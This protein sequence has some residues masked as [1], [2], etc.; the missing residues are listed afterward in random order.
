MFLDLAKALTHELLWLSSHHLI[1]AIA[2]QRPSAV[3][4][5][6]E[7]SEWDAA[8]IGVPQGSILGPL[9]FAL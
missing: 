4:S 7:L 5:Y 2:M 1:L 3:L 9:L 8:S 6:G